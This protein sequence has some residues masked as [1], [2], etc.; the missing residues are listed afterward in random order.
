VSSADHDSLD[1]VNQEVSRTLTELERRL[2]ELEVELSL[3]DPS[4]LSD[5]A[6]DGPLG[7][8]PDGR[9]T[10]RPA[11]PSSAPP[12]DPGSVDELAHGRADVERIAHE[13]LRDYDELLRMRKRLER[14][15][16]DLIGDYERLLESRD[17]ARPFSS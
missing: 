14:A 8:P 13:L 10:G 5:P 6:A 12:G 1:Q 17:P 15:R 7:A 3:A 2:G 9:A 11:G 16:G 4:R